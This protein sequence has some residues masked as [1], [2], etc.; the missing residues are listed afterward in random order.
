[1]CVQ[2][3][4]THHVKFAPPI[5]AKRERTIPLLALFSLA[6]DTAR[7]L[8]LQNRGSCLQTDSQLPHCDTIESVP[9]Q[10]PHRRPNHGALSFA[11]AQ[12]GR[13]A[14]SAGAD[15]RHCSAFCVAAAALLSVLVAFFRAS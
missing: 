5:H 14:K 15:F 1:H 13:R 8:H 4:S 10:T 7:S 6:S 11:R 2:S 9:W 12:R 3:G